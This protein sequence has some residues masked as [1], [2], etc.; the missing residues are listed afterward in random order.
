LAKPPFGIVRLFASDRDDR[1]RAN[2]VGAHTVDQ[3]PAI[4]V[5]ER[6][7]VFQKLLLI[8]C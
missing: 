4:V 8:G 3:V 6:T 2:A 7:N 5:S 1:L